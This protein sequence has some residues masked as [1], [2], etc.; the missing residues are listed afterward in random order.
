MS[1]FSLWVCSFQIYTGLM[2][3]N[4]INN[5]AQKGLEMEIF[6]FLFLSKMPT[7]LYFSFYHA[8]SIAM[9][10]IVHKYKKM[11]ESTNMDFAL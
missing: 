4:V 8:N 3:L 11:F 9:L 10:C 6:K 1:L 7:T 5:T 2:K